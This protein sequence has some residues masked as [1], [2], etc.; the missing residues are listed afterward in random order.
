MNRKTKRIHMKNN[1]TISLPVYY[2]LIIAQFILPMIAASIDMF[3]TAPELELLDQTLYR[4]PQSWEL[5][6]ISLVGVVIFII[7]VGLCLRQEWARK[8]YI[9]TFFPTFLIYFLP[10]MHWFYMSSYAAIFN[11]IAYVCAGVLFII[12]ASPALYQSI[13][14][15][16]S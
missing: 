14:T 10:Y 3:S 11:D 4:D 15:K 12:L 16:K 5:A 7:T 2:G 8:A 9:Y 13:F 1:A 6:I